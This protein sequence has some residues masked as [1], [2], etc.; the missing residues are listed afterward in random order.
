[1]DFVS[2]LKKNKKSKNTDDYG[3]SVQV[4]PCLNCE[5]VFL[6]THLR[7]CDHIR[8][9]SLYCYCL[10]CSSL[11]HKLHQSQFKIYLYYHHVHQQDCQSELE[12]LL[13]NLGHRKWE[14]SVPYLLHIHWLHSGHYLH[15][16]IKNIESWIVE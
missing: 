16:S 6:Y 14:V 11:I 10:V 9:Q 4:F 3:L 15:Q 2:S 8:A 12:R 1:M 13:P 5:A 7:S